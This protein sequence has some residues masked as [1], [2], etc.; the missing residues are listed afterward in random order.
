MMTMDKQ[1]KKELSSAYVQ[2]FRPMGIFQIR[3]QD[4]GKI[5]VDA[6]MDLDGMR[7]RI[8]FMST[9]GS[10]FHELKEDWQTYGGDR[11][12]FEI[13]DELKPQEESPADSGDLTKYKRE[14]NELLGLWLEKLEPY[15]ERGYNKRRR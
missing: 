15:G 14:L 2:C 12:V 7:N 6:S 13:L 8:S 11:F 9:M 10:P 5:Y 1:K 3:S 4:N